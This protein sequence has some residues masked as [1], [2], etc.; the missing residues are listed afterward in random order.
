MMNTVPGK[1]S[2]MSVEEEIWF[3]ESADNSCNKL[4]CIAPAFN[5]L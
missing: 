2:A 5:V 4:D 1:V 3:I